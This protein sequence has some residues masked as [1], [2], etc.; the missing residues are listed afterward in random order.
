M[1]ELAARLDGVNLTR[2]VGV[3]SDANIG[4]RR[5]SHC[6][7]LELWLASADSGCVA[8]SSRR[9]RVDEFP[10]SGTTAVVDAVACGRQCEGAK[11]DL[12]LDSGGIRPRLGKR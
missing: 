7:I 1:A 11:I 3:V 6:E 8:H 5:A 4:H 9:L 2:K 10:S 12:V